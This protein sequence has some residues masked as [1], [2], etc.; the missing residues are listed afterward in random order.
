MARPRKRNG[1]SKRAIAYLR[2]S[3]DEQTVQQQRDAIEAWA[4][5]ERVT[6]ASW[7]VDEDIS[8]A[9]S[10][11]DRP[12]MLDALSSL[13]ASNA[14]LLVA[15]KR[16]RLARDVSQAATIE[17]LTVEAGARVVTADGLDASDTPEGAMIRGM[18]DV[19]AQYE[20]AVIRART[21]VALASKKKRG[22]AV[23]SAP[24]GWR[25]SGRTLQEGG[26]SVG[27]RL[28][29]VPDEQAA[30]ARIRLLQAAGESHRAI[31]QALTREGYK[32][33][34]RAWHA[35]TIARVLSALRAA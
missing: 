7:H 5:R 17:K 25:N 6:I 34:G 3:T 14:G 10:V 24:Y 35:T 9:A 12:G 4:E 19:F 33:R 16:D 20:L 26:K 8:G 13:R 21:R 31:A 28:V 2:V 15:A 27:G 30:I 18:L 32:A 1:D 23:G 22:E 29:R 11:A